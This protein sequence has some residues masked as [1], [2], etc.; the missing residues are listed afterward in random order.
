MYIINT[1]FHAGHSI[2]DLIID[3]IQSQLIPAMTRS[4]LFSDIT[5]AEILVSVD[6]NC[7][8]FTL[9]SSTADLDKAM[10]WLR[11]EGQEFFDG[12]HK[13]Y[14]E[15]VVYFTTPMRRLK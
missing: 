11:N 4:A 13:R 7:F 2:A 9:Q 14:G 6:P 3:E 1:S 8:S 5:M 12:L 15:N 10:N